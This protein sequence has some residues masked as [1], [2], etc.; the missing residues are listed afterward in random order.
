MDRLSPSTILVGVVCFGFLYRLK[1][2]ERQWVLHYRHHVPS[3]TRMHSSR[4][5][6]ACGSSRPYRG[7]RGLPQCMLGYTHPTTPRCGPGDLSLGVGLETPPPGQTPQLPPWV[8]A[9]RPPP[10]PAA[11]HAGIPP[12]R[13]TG[14]PPLNRMTGAE[15][16]PCPKLRLRAV[17]SIAVSGSNIPVEYSCLL[18]KSSVSVLF[19]V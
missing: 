11:R 3:T 17:T 18:S 14:I 9:W 4:I 19:E 12:A 6:T 10:R 5:V 16:L 13:H 8:W 2:C 1:F 7:L 15:I